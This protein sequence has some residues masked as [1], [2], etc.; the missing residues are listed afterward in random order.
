MV[1]LARRGYAVKAPRFDL[2]LSNR[3]RQTVPMVTLLLAVVALVA[4]IQY[5][6]ALRERGLA[7]DARESAVSRSEHQRRSI[8]NAHT[9]TADPQ[10]RELMARQRYAME[11]ARDLME[12][13]WHPGIALLLLDLATD[14]R[15]IDMVFETRSAQEAL[16][17]VDWLEQQSATERVLVK[18]QTAKPGQPDSPVETRVQVI[19]R[20]LPA[21]PSP[22]ATAVATSRAATAPSG[23]R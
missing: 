20:P 16:A 23:Q 3:P 17:Y 14:T 9:S 21:L 5:L 11:P 6:E 19:W 4:V 13:G 15:Q 1:A 7:L 2:H 22:A 8:G 12:R 18:R 10:A